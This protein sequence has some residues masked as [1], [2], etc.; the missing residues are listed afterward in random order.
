MPRPAAQPK[1]PGE[2]A[3]PEANQPEGDQPM[4]R[5]AAQ[6]KVPGEVAQ[7][8]A[9]QPEAVVDQ[10]AAAADEQVSVSKASL[11]ALLARVAALE[12]APSQAARKVA[13]PTANLPDADSLDVATLKN[14][15][16]TKQGWLVPE[17]YGSNPNAP[18]AL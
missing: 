15:V 8:E 1:V 7:P 3:Q 10:P 11:D 12:A 6:P 9:N 13:N 14:P 4:P 5:P 16:L 2:V 17:T 18:K